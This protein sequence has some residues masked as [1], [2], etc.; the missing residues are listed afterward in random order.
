MVAVLAVM[1]VSDPPTINSAASEI[2][3]LTYRLPMG[4]N[5]VRALH[6]LRKLRS[7][8]WYCEYNHRFRPLRV[9]D[10]F[11]VAYSNFDYKKVATDSY[12]HA[13]RLVSL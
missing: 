13:W 8:H 12:F 4:P 3:S 6:Q 1:V 10:A 7:C 5:S 11:G 2:K 9:A